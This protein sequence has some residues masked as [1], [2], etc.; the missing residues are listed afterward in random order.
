MA[1]DRVLIVDDDANQADMLRGVVEL[2]N[3]KAEVETSSL[4]ALERLRKERFDIVVSDLR[5]PDL[6]GYQLF[7][8]V[9]RFRPEQIF[10]IMTAFGT[11]ETAVDAIRSGVFDFVQK[12]IHAKELLTR[13]DR[14]RQLAALRRENVELRRKVRSQYERRSIVGDSAVMKQL[15]EQAEMAANSEATILI[16]GE[17]GTGKEIVANHIHY[18]SPRADGPFVKVNCAAIPETLLE[19]E[20]FGHIKGAFTGAIG[21]RE[22]R[23]ERANGGTIFLDEIGEVLPQLQVKLLRILQEREFERLGSSETIPVDVRVITAT[24]HDLE[25]RVAEGAFREDLF[26][27]INVIPLRIPPLRERRDDVLLLANHFLDRAARKNRRAIRRIT[28]AAENALE[29]YDWPGNVRELENTI[30][31]AVVMS[32]DEE[33]GIEDLSF[34]RGKV[35]ESDRRR[36]LDEFLNSRLSLDELERTYIQRGLE[37]AEG[38]QSRA[39]KMLGVSRRTLQYRAEKHGLLGKG[40]ARATDGGDGE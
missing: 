13:F 26:Y 18:Q 23:F 1:F 36:V 27:R 29:E 16:Q 34:V 11:I 30:E 5:M 24:H 14:A 15:L 10:I 8:K 35:G 33:I 7:L 32:R 9:R 31:R 28:P 3:W 2:A 20:L 39:A 25:Q 22:G 19:D 6:D 38:N 37:R 12:P 40:E 4:R 21:P 17:S